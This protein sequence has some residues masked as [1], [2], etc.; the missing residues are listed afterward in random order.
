VRL[1]GGVFLLY[2]GG[3]TVVRQPTLEVNPGATRWLVTAFGSTL[4]LTLTN[5]TTILSFAAIFAGLGLG[6]TPG[7]R[8]SAVLMVC[9][10]FIGSALWWLLLSGAV[11]FFR[12]SLTPDRL[13]WVNRVSGT[14]LV[15][16]G[17]IPL[18]S[19]VG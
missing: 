17:L 7:D 1:A 13:R 18:F 2:L 8:G 11:G 19:L 15:G 6:T 10:V 16:F 3:R 9:G 5:P 4:A 12:R 14:L